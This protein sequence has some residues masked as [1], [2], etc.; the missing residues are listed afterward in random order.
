MAL[1]WNLQSV[2]SFESLHNPIWKWAALLGIVLAGF[3]IGKIVCFALDRQARWLQAA[4]RS[5]IL[6]LFLTALSRPVSMAVLGVALF[7]GQKFLVLDVELQLDGTY[8]ALAD[9]GIRTLWIQISAALLAVAAA[10]AAFRLVD[11]LEHLLNEVTS[12]TETAL[13]DQLVPLI[14]K[15]IRVFVVLIA[16]LFIAQNIFQWNVSALIAGLGIGGLAFALAAKDSLANLF[17]SAVIFADRPFAMGDWVKVQGQDGTVEEVGFRST[18]IRTFFGHLLTIPNSVVANDTLENVSSRP[19]IRRNLDIGV[20][21]DTPPDR[22]ERALEILGEMLDAR[23][24]HFHA[25]YSYKLVFKDFGA[26]SLN[27]LVVYY[28]TP[29]D[30]WAAQAFNH[31]FNL[32]LLRRFNDEG[33]EFAF[34]TQTLHLQGV[35]D[36]AP[37]AADAENASPDP[38]SGS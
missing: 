29:P 5:G 34:P 22:L 23:V 36:Q 35:G 8:T 1:A 24:A 14:R 6:H 21:Y 32:E 7:I 17:G 31:D 16:G 2:W 38:R 33:I 26:Y 15:S 30:Y 27:I 13:D 10:W 20:T 18:R 37:P 9:G 19:F 28:Y 25:D 12:R 3:I 11:I 4:K